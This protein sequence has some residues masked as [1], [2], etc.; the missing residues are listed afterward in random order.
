MPVAVGE[1]EPNR[2]ILVKANQS[3]IHISLQILKKIIINVSFATLPYLKTR[4]KDNYLLTSQHKPLWRRHKRLPE[5]KR[6]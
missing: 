2:I 3:S 6:R 4:V 1:E 5:Q